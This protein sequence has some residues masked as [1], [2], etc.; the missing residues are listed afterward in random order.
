[1]I[2][3]S[4]VGNFKPT[5]LSSPWSKMN[6]L[7]AHSV[8]NYLNFPKLTLDPRTNVLVRTFSFKSVLKKNWIQ[9]RIPQQNQNKLG[10][11]SEISRMSDKES[12]ERKRQKI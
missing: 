12:R 1:M 4:R 8:E 7:S 10:K 11:N 3:Q 2:L 6:N 9:E 5:L